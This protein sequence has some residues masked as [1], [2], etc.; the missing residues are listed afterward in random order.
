MKPL[1]PVLAFASVLC[2][3]CGDSSRVMEPT[4]LTL[5]LG[6][7]LPQMTEKMQELGA[8][9]VTAETRFTGTRS[10]SGLQKHLWWELPNKAVVSVLLAGNTEADLKVVA[11][12]VGEP[13]KGVTG[14][15]A[16]QSQQRV[17]IESL[18]DVRGRAK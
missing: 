15:D 12:T 2:C 13:G 17:L 4:R 14:I 11:I 8:R 3:G 18:P 6:D 1:M 10:I 9:D 7:T 5:G 16:W